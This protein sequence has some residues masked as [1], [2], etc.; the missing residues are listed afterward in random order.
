MPLM[1]STKLGL[2]DLL[3][4]EKLL[5]THIKECKRIMPILAKHK[6]FGCIE[7]YYCFQKSLEKI[8]EATRKFKKDQSQI[9]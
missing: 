9:R 7:A 4:F 6:Y 2:P 3:Q 1:F 5:Q 8:L